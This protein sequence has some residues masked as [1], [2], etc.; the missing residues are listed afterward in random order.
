MTKNTRQVLSILFPW[1]LLT[2]AFWFAVPHWHVSAVFFTKAFSVAA[3]LVLLIMY[4]AVSGD[5]A[6]KPVSVTIALSSIGLKLMASTGIFIYYFLKIAPA[7]YPLP[8]L[9]VGGVIYLIYT[10][11]VAWYGMYWGGSV[12]SDA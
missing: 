3:A 8:A 2:T 1:G 7:E 9:K 5:R 12:K 4:A 6:G 11:L 10:I